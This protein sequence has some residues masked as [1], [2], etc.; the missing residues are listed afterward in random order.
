MDLQALR[1]QIAEIGPHPGLSE[2]HKNTVLAYRCQDISQYEFRQRYTELAAKIAKLLN[3]A[4]P[5]NLEEETY[6]MA[7]NYY[8]A[9]AKCLSTYLEGIDT[10]TLWLDSSDS[11]A[12]ENSQRIFTLADEILNRAID[13]AL[14]I[15]IEFQETDEA[16]MR[17]LGAQSAGT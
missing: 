6:H 11:R 16:L 13:E 9:I 10:I 7:A 4:S 17:T 1:E 2:W 8:T 12:L 14:K 15:E 5:E 3:E